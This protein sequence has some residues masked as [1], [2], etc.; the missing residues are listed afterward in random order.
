MCAHVQYMC[1]CAEFQS[2]LAFRQLHNMPAFGNSDLYFICRMK[3]LT[4]DIDYCRDECSDCRWLP[5]SDLATDP[6]STHLSR[7]VAELALK[8]LAEGW[9][10]VDIA[11]D[12]LLLEVAPGRT[13]RYQLWHRSL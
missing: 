10:S 7:R 3:P 6:D 13:I 1:M 5:L 12:H 9:A 8:G 2:V 11:L 4:F